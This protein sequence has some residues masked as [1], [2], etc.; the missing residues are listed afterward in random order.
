MA[1]LLHADIRREVDT[2]YVTTRADSNY[3]PDRSELN[4][5]PN[6]LIMPS[7]HTDITASFKQFLELVF[8]P[9]ADDSR[10]AI[11]IRDVKGYPETRASKKFLEPRL[12][13]QKHA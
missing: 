10:S 9:L 6:E 4:K 13:N 12:I 5:I 1:S 11:P 8:V 7:Q 2:G 3:V